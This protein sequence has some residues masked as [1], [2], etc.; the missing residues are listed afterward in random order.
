MVNKS[1]ALDKLSRSAEER[2]LLA[3]VWDKADAARRGAPSWTPFLSEAQR[4]VVERLMPALGGPRHIYSGGYPSAE[5]RVC[6]FL[7]EWQSEEDWSPPFSALRCVWRSG[8]RLTHRDF[9]GAVLGA[10]IEREKLGDILVGKES[11]DLLVVSELVPSLQQHLTEAGR[12][13]LRVEEVSLPELTLPEKTV[14]VIHDTVNTPRLDA[15]VA[16]GFSMSRSKAAGLIASGKVA[17]NHREC[18]K[19]DRQVAEGD[20]LTCR[21]L[22][23]CIIK[24][25]PGQSKKGRTMLVIERYL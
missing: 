6:A 7:P 12:A 18:T 13:K 22:G 10:G 2:Q 17:L 8:E 3:R 11:C 15:V 19:A 9:L 1:A 16:S 24:E 23:K 5:R 20:V 14:K 21:G 4:Q 25:V